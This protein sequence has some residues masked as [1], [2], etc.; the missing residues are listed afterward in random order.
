MMYDNI[1]DIYRMHHGPLAIA[2][3]WIL[4]ASSSGIAANTPPPLSP[5]Q[6]NP[7]SPAVAVKPDLVAQIQGVFC[8]NQGGGQY[9]VQVKIRIQNMSN[10]KTWKDISTRVLLDSPDPALGAA[11]TGTPYTIA[12]R[13]SAAKAM[14]CT[15]TFSQ[16]RALTPSLS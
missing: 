11:F 10:N 13:C 3:L 12:A 1:F 6:N 16:R 9:N 2:S 7:P 4:L 8:S 5:S 15:R 14:W